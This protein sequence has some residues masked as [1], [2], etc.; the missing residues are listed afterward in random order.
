MRAYKFS[1]K[2][3]S[4]GIEVPDVLLKR[5]PIDQVVRLIVLVKEQ[6]DIEEQAIWS[7]LTSAQFLANYEQADDIYDRMDLTG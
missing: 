5:L 4:E 7:C 2:V 1:A 3:T 6:T